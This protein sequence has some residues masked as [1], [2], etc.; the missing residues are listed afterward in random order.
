MSADRNP[1][2]NDRAVESVTF[3]ITENMNKAGFSE[4]K[5]VDSEFIFGFP[6]GGKRWISFSKK[7]D[8]LSDIANKIRKKLKNTLTKEFEEAAF[9]EIESTL[10]DHK[11]EIFNSR[12]QTKTIPSNMYEPKRAEISERIQKVRELIKQTNLTKSEYST[13]LC[14]K[15]DVLQQLTLELIPELWLPLHLLISLYAILHI[16][17]WTLPLMVILLGVPSSLKTVALEM[18]VDYLNTFS[19]DE[20][21]PGS[22]VSHMSGKSEEE[23]QKDDMLP[24]LRNKLCIFPELAP[25]FSAKD[26]DFRRIVSKF[27]R[28][29]DGKGYQSDSG[30]KGHR[31]YSGELMF[32]AAGA[33]VEVSYHVYRIFGF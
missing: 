31:G 24:K 33:A 13:V 20:F 11:H 8:S 4:F 19:T 15:Y 29:L 3:E 28:L 7:K 21:T 18:F 14:K 17:N 32:V 5:L 2:H 22:F 10:I 30:A 26:E 9:Q 25:I 1:S 23:L 27:L 16:N 6:E 12:E